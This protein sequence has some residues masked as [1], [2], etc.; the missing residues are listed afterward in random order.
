MWLHP[1][2]LF[3]LWLPSMF[4]LSRVRYSARRSLAFVSL[5]LRMRVKLWGTHYFLLPEAV[6][7]S[8][9]AMHEASKKLTECLQEVYEPDWPGRDDT[10][11]IAEVR[12]SRM[13]GHQAWLVSGD[14]LWSC[15]CVLPF[16]RHMTLERQTQHWEEGKN[17]GKWPVSL[18]M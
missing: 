9:L 12:L 4:V 14:Q 18:S 8:F 3:S 1:Q 2:F 5:F 10:N 13:W 7:S 15:V 11:K 6:P 17:E 16:F